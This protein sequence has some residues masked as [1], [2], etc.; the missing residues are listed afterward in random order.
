[1]GETAVF[2]DKV[3]SK[4]QL[5]TKV[6]NKIKWGQTTFE[7]LLQ[8]SDGWASKVRYQALV[9]VGVGKTPDKA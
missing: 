5:S 1:V 8:A 3:E 7:I 9:L 2:V 4:K 6:S